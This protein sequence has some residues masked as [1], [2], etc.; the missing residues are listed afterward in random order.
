MKSITPSH[1]NG[2]ELMDLLVKYQVPFCEGNCIKYL[3][4][5]KQKNGLE[6]LYKCRTYLDALIAH[7]ELLKGEEQHEG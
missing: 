6:D 1:Y 3:W 7:A 5:W 4:R 2:T